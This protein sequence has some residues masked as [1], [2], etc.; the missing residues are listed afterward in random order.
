MRHSL[1]GA[2]GLAAGLFVLSAVPAQAQRESSLLGIKLWR[3][4][5]DV[6]KKHGQPTRI[7]VGAVTTTMAGQGG[8]GGGGMAG[9]GM[10]MGM[11][12]YGGAPMG[13]AGMS[14]YGG[15]GPM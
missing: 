2:V 12:P 6:L 15:G 5:R 9:P 1:R 4:W 13:G 11:G 3:T 14:P 7:E 8:A 10:G